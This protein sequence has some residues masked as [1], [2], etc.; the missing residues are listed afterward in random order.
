MQQ[1]PSNSFASV[2]RVQARHVTPARLP[3]GVLRGIRVAAARAVKELGLCDV[4]IVRG[5]VLE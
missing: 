2:S 3:L 5:W 1:N 4:A